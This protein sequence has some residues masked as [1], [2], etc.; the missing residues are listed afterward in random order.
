MP[1]PS[2]GRKHL[3]AM[4]REEFYEMLEKAAARTLR[5]LSH[6]LEVAIA[7]HAAYPEKLTRPPVGELL[8]G[9]EVP[10]PVKGRPGKRKEGQSHSP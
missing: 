3:S 9:L 2:K 1:K 5:A 6:E 10:A 8:A 7:R 4:I